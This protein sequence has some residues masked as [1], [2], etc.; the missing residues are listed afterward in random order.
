MNISYIENVL[1]LF[2][3]LLLFHFYSEQMFA[4]QKVCVNAL[5]QAFAFPRYGHMS[6][7]CRYHCV[8]AL[9][10][11]FAFPQ[12]PFKNPLFMR[13]CEPV[14]AGIYLTILIISIFRHFLG[15][16]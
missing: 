15:F 10:Q 4:L 3:K 11:A 6:L 9:L 5:L 1:M 14:F 13:V 12:Y 8:N 7:S 16:F 2:C